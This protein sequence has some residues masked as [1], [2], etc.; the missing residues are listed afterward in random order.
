[1]FLKHEVSFRV[2]PRYRHV[3][4]QSLAPYRR[5]PEFLSLNPA[6]AS[7]TDAVTPERSGSSMDIDLSRFL[8]FHNH[9]C[10]PGC[11]CLITICF[12]FSSY[13]NPR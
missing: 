9:A 7:S 1:M 8:T 10:D 3:V 13:S 4:A 6:N 12:S 2:G 11:F 5:L